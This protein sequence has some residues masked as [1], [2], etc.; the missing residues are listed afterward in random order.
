MSR[1]MTS[2]PCIVT[3]LVGC[4]PVALGASSRA[5]PSRNQIGSQVMA[6]TSGKSSAWR[7]VLIPPANDTLRCV[8]FFSSNH[9]RQPMCADFARMSIDSD[10]RSVPGGGGNAWAT[11]DCGCKWQLYPSTHIFSWTIIPSTIILPLSAVYFFLNNNTLH[12]YTTVKWGGSRNKSVKWGGSRNKSDPFDQTRLT[13]LIAFYYQYTAPK[14]DS[15]KKAN[16]IN[17]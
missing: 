2:G 8:P 11:S 4:G 1:S 13:V 5:I 14:R 7:H 12:D 9:P 3:W 10:L 15:Y 6:A 16:F 17:K